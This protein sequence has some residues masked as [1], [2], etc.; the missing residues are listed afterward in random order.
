[1]FARSLRRLGPPQVPN[2]IDYDRLRTSLIER[3]LPYLQDQADFR[4]TDKLIATLT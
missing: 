3:N 1:M 2:A 4:N